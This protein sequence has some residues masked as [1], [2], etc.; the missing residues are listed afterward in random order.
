MLLLYCPSL[1]PMRQ[2]GVTIELASPETLEELLD[3]LGSRPN[4]MRRVKAHSPVPA[5]VHV[6]RH[7]GGVGHVHPGSWWWLPTPPRT[8]LLLVRATPAL[9]LSCPHLL[10][11]QL[12]M[13][14]AKQRTH[15]SACSVQSSG[16]RCS[17]KDSPA[18]NQVKPG[19]QP[20]FSCLMHVILYIAT[21]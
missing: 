13:L 7:I 18:T 20:R 17:V 21:F 1:F 14:L 12:H 8:A 2:P 9:L 15:C 3:S 11:R 5:M 10:L 6:M 19:T 4:M 16:M